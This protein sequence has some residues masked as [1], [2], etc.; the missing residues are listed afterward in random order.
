VSFEDI[1]AGKE[2]GRFE[3]RRTMLDSIDI[4]WT[5]PKVF[6]LVILMISGATYVLGGC[7]QLG[8]A[9][10]AMASEYNDVYTAEDSDSDSDNK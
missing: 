6:L 3:S 5:P 4:V 8:K 9:M 1:G 7:S 10:H 2:K